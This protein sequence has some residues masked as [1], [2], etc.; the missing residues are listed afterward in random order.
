MVNPDLLK[1]LFDVMEAVR[2]L[3]SFTSGL[4]LKD[5][6][7]IEMKWAIERGISIIGEAKYKAEKL[8]KNLKVSNLKNIISMRHIVVHNY[9]M[10]ESEL[11]Y[12]I[13]KKYL[14]ILKNEI[15]KYL[16]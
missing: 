8:E 9:D 5:I 10:I 16:E 11:L 3:E 2:N 6:E 4:T 15:Q 12:I 1:Y 13:I 14:P 7:K